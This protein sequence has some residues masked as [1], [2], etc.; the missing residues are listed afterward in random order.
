MSDTISLRGAV[1]T[2]QR[3]DSAHKHV[4]GTAV[5]ADDEMEPVGTLHAYL[6]LSEAAHAEIVSVDLSAVERAPGVVG[7]LTGDDIPGAN[8]VSPTG[9]HDDPV[10]AE[11]KTEFWG[12][13]L[14]AVVAET[15]DQARR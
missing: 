15:R 4:T 10:F 9:K 13:P 2:S 7:V 1:H 6:G 14:F 5:Y 8:D 11:G 3:H 12:Q